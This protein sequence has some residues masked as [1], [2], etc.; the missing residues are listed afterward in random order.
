M[1]GFKNVLHAKPFQEK[2]KRVAMPLQS[3]GVEKPFAQWGLDV[4]G[5]LNP[6]SSKGHVYII[7]ETDYFTKW[8]EVVAL[9]NVDSE[10]LV[11]FL[12]ENIL[13]RFGVPEKLI[14]NNGSIFIGSKFT[15][16]CGEYGIIIGK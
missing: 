6:K 10:K 15:L 5:P 1:S 16:F 3:I 13:S 12:K 14:T 4:I 2:K 9:R 11:H 7:T 8:Q